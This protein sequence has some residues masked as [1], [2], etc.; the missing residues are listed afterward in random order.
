MDKNNMA[1]MPTLSS[2]IDHLWLESGLSKNTLISYR[3]DLYQFILFLSK[4]HSTEPNDH[5]LLSVQ[6]LDIEQWM[7]AQFSEVNTSTINRRLSTLRRFYQWAIQENLMDYDP[8]L[9][10]ERAKQPPK[11]SQ[12]IK[13][14]RGGTLTECTRSNHA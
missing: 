9:H 6:Q 11:K 12:N 4:Q 8:C 1:S 14:K 13:R 2:F 5:H 7:S 3:Q 10:I